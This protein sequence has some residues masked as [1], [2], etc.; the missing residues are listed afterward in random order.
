M[1]GL[2]GEL[3]LDGAVADRVAVER[4]ADCQSRR[5]PDG[6]GIWAR[7]PVTLA[8]RRLAIIDLTATGSQPMVDDVLGLTIVINGCIY[9][10]RDLR[11]ELTGRATR[12][13]R[14]PTRR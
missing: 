12:S 9:N 11:K 5:G 3:R 10:Y 6:H 7:G 4:M 8:H 14:A 1:C 2:A 13:S